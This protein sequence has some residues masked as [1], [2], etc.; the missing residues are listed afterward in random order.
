MEAKDAFG[1][2]KPFSIKFVK[3]STGEIVKLEG[4]VCTSIHSAGS[5]LNI[6]FPGEFTPKTIQKCL[7]IEFNGMDVYI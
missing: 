2:N 5:T 1:K 3:K 4:A 6:F 7:I